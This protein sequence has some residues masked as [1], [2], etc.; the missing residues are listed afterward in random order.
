MKKKKDNNVVVDFKLED[1]IENETRYI[2]RNIADFSTE[3]SILYGINRNIARHIPLVLDGLKPVARR[4]LVTLYN[5][6]TPNK[7]TKLDTIAGLTMGHYHPHA[8]EPVQLVLGRMGQ[9]WSN[10]IMYIDPHGNF[11]NR[12]GLP[13]AAGRYISAKLSKFAYKCFFEDYKHVRIDKTETY[14]GDDYEPD[15]LPTRYPIGIV[16]PQFSSIGYGTAANIAPYNFTEVLEATLK[17]INNP[18]SKINLIPD[19]PTGCDVLADDNLIKINK[20]G[21]G[22]VSTRATCEIDYKSNE[23]LITSLPLGIGVD[24]LMADISKAILSKKID[25]ISDIK[26]YTNPV[27][28]YYTK[29][30]LHRKANA[31][32][33]FKSLL[34]LNV[35]LTKTYAVQLKFIDNYKE[36]SYSPKTYILRWLDFRRDILKSMYNSKYVSLIN[37]QHLNDVKIFVFNKDN[38]L[39][40]TTICR[41]AKDEE[42]A[43][44]KLYKRYKD[45]P[46]H[47]TTLQAA[48]IQKMKMSDYNKASRDRFKDRAKELKLEISEVTDILS[49]PNKIDAIIEDQLKEGI[50]LFGQPR[51]S[52]IIRSNDKT[53][54]DTNHIVAISNDNYIKKIDIVKGEIPVI[55]KL[56]NLVSQPTIAIKVR[57]TKSITVVDSYGYITKLP[58]SGLPSST[59][60]ENGLQV[61]RFFHINGNV[62]GIIDNS[63][64]RE[65]SNFI[66]V[67]K[68]GCSKRISSVDLHKKKSGSIIKLNDGDELISIIQCSEKSKESIIIYTNKGNGIRIPIQDIQLY[69]LSA[70]GR[71]SITLDDEYVAGVDKIESRCKYLFYVTSNGRVKKTELKLLPIM[72]KRSEPIKLIPIKDNDYLISILSIHDGEIVRCYRKAD[73]SVDINTDDIK[74]SLRVANGEKKIKTGNS[75]NVF[76][77][78]HIL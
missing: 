62:I 55:G 10:N 68:Y 49:N 51:R 66:L 15:Y 44:N 23:I 25:G 47:M 29:I 70:M 35:G 50:E 7:Y 22:K 41:Q 65:E 13:P 61:S 28:G 20:D 54:P 67:T 60:D 19:F 2:D 36:Y 52:K 58:V 37:E 14:T 31:D 39:D 12:N 6:K 34:D 53:I 18:D 27:S 4:A 77:V 45:S 1:F 69:G 26:D 30:I 8:P 11:G 38:I 59:Q 71:V 42:D 57:N 72:R 75:G 24:D 5:L 78:V 43:I 63:K 21:H 17:L 73:E 48:T 16:N 33:V 40:T 32:K 76:S 56:G 46:I 64:Y 3:S 9:D 74:V